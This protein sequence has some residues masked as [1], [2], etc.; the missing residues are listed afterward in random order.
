M[1]NSRHTPQHGKTWLYTGVITASL[2]LGLLG[3]QSVAAHADTATDTDAS[4][5]ATT[6]AN[7]QSQEVTLRTTAN[8]QPMTTEVTPDVPV[9]P[10]TDV[11]TTGTEDIEDSIVEVPGNENANTNGSVNPATSEPTSPPAAPAEITETPAITPPPADT[12]QALPKSA[13]A[14]APVALTVKATPQVK[15]DIDQWM[16]N[17]TLQ[18]LVWQQLKRD[19]KDRTWAS[20]KD[21]TQED[22]LLLKSLSAQAFGVSLYIDGKTEFS[23]AG[24]QYATN[25]VDLDLYNSLNIHNNAFR[26]DIVDIS[27][28]RHLENLVSIQLGNNRIS[29]ISPIAGLTKVNK[30]QIGNNCI[31]D[32]S[33]LKASQYTKTFNYDAQVVE[34]SVVYVNKKTRTYTMTNPM[35]APQG[36]TLTASVGGD[37]T[38]IPIFPIGIHDHPQAKVYYNGGTSKPVGDQLVYTNIVD[39]IMPGPTTS[40]FAGYDAYPN[41]YTYFLTS[42]YIDSNSGRVINLFTP[43]VMADEAE[44]VTVNY[45]DEKGTALKAPVT[46]T[47][48]VGESYAA[49]A[50]SFEGYTLTKTPTNASGTFGDK[51][52]TVTF[53]YKKD[54]GTVTPPVDPQPDVT[55]TITVQFQTADGVKVAADQLLTG[56]TGE[57]YTTSPATVDGTKYVLVSTPGNASGTFGTSDDTVTYIYAEIEDSGDGDG[58]TTEPDVDEP[59]GEDADDGQVT[60]DRPDTSTGSQGDQISGHPTGT[61]SQSP[62]QL[63]V[64]PD[65]QTATTLP[66]T[67]E[68]TVSPAWGVALLLSVL[69]FLGF[70]SRRK[71][72]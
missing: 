5:L 17:E 2:G 22:M 31:A 30:L 34:Q 67:D 24:L 56:K 63:A 53:V 60:V 70:K 14:A 66:Q 44:P 57:T 64:K 33:S 27:P 21:V 37:R 36:V 69:G 7:P 10:V 19:N 20:A 51:A 65:G 6:E 71:D 62:Q 9:E 43:Y 48:M 11:T 35:K 1:T 72:R 50:E 25:L 13:R 26:G 8:D 38:G 68:R 52:I 46:L 32:L 58:I 49:E 61:A 39:Q 23:L 41:A 40:P 59:D 16:P 45:V 15:A 47:G 3:T 54:G 12:A 18:D 29:D 4:R 55:V 28:L 42:T